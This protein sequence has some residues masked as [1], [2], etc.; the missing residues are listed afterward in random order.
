MGLL[1]R[2][3]RVRH[4]GNVHFSWSGGSAQATPTGTPGPG[5][6]RF[7]VASVSALRELLEPTSLPEDMIEEVLS[8]TNTL[9]LL[10]APDEL[11]AGELVLCHPPLGPGEVRAVVNQ[12]EDHR[13]WR[14]TVVTRDRPGLLAGTSATL[15]AAH[16]SI[17]DAAVTVLPRSRLAMQRLTVSTRPG[18]MS[19]VDWSQLGRDLRDN[20]A[21]G[22]LPASPFV[23]KGAVV[24]EAQPQDLGRT[25]VTV[26]APDGVG[27]LHA[28]A[29]WFEANGC[30]VEACRAGTEGD[31]ARSVF[32]ITGPVDTAALASE[33]SGPDAGSIVTRVATTPLHVTIG[34]IS[35]LVR[36]TKGAVRTAG[37][38]ASLPCRRR[39]G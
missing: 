26:E 16:L 34:V 1:G 28:A 29:A 3:V 25:V 4:T 37:K 27:L 12:T 14:V 19:E 33:L 15:S 6:I 31:R 39:N 10:G 8:D 11:V 22:E 38:L 17:V 35:G 36:A 9:W 32:I 21:G 24:I 5:T 30:N 7:A 18:E 23:P 20:L 13:L 2:D